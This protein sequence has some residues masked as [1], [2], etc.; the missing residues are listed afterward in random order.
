MR[1]TGPA[2]GFV[3][4]LIRAV[5][6]GLPGKTRLARLALRPFL[7]NKSV[8]VPD[9]FGNVLLLPSLQEPIAL[10]LFAF[11]VYESDTLSAILSHLSSAGV[12][13]DVGANIGAL[14]LPVAAQRPDARIVCIEADPE[15]VPLLQWNIMNNGRSNVTVVKCV[16][17]P[18]K[19]EKSFYPAPAEK[20]GMGSLGPQFGA[21]PVILQ[22]C[23]LDE[24]LDELAVG[25]VDVVKLDIEGAEFGAL[26]GLGRRL[27]SNKPPIIILEFTDW[28]E[29]RIDGQAAGDA[30]QF[31]LRLRYRLFR[32]SY[33]GM[34][35]VPITRPV[36]TGSAMILALPSQT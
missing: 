27:R 17:G 26:H 10:G 19:G 33:R 23:A 2:F 28:A 29:T 6:D 18:A 11:G 4:S 15:I 13:V 35:G 21:T 24:V 20:F 9:S 31:L 32:L 25:N 5:P 14:A 30:Q 3:R 1:G 12:F 8:C 7:Q 16:A 34:P 36:T 22:Q